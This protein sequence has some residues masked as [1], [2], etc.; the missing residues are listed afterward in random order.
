MG[1]NGAC[2]DD[3]RKYRYR[4][5]RDFDT[6][7]GIVTFIM[8]NPSTADATYNDPTITR[9]I[10]FAKAWGYGRLEVVN[11]FAY[12]ST[13]PSV[14]LK[15]NNPVGDENDRHIIEAVEKSNMVVAAWGEKGKILKRNKKVE[16]LL[17]NLSV[18]YALE[19]T[20]KGFPK[21]PLFVKED[22][23]PIEFLR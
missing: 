14:L 5:W 4:L 15:A 16:A 18:I 7:S 9:C 20:K 12:R 10:G 3:S 21:H 6:G 22:V 2:I 11:L 1:D 13:D 23:I 8:L 19:I 17:K